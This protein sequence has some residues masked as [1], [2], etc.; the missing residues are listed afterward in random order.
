MKFAESHVSR[1]NLLP[2]ISSKLDGSL[3]TIVNRFQRLHGP[4]IYISIHAGIPKQLLLSHKKL[5]PKLKYTI[6]CRF[7]TAIFY[8][9]I[10]VLV[11]ALWSGRFKVSMG[12]RTV[13]ATSSRRV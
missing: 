3:L 4:G 8:R 9:K 13:L 1:H 6:M 10:A 2:S 12:N 5:P 11:G 7:A